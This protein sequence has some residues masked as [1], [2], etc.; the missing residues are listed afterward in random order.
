MLWDGKL[1]LFYI[2]RPFLGLSFSKML[3]EPAQVGNVAI[4]CNSEGNYLTILIL[5]ERNSQLFIT[6]QLFEQYS[7]FHFCKEFLVSRF[8]CFT[9]AMT[10]M[11]EQDW[12]GNAMGSFTLLSLL[13]KNISI[14]FSCVSV[15]AK[16]LAFLHLYNVKLKEILYMKT[17]LLDNSLQCSRRPKDGLF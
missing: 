9:S 3:K 13:L 5:L 12:S 10:N 7:M 2:L 11:S 8:N 15:Y 1:N 16:K 17:E 4:P 14:V 6:N